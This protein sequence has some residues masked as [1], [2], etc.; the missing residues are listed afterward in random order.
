MSTQLSSGLWRPLKRHR[1]YAKF[2]D[3]KWICALS[4]SYPIYA[5]LTIKFSISHCQLPP[6][7]EFLAHL[8][9]TYVERNTWCLAVSSLHTRLPLS[10]VL[11]WLEMKFAYYLKATRNGQ[12]AHS[13]D[14]TGHWA[15]SAE[16]LQLDWAPRT[17]TERRGRVWISESWDW[18]CGTVWPQV[19][20]WNEQTSKT[21]DDDDDDDR[22]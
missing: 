17:A 11:S 8:F 7:A 13:L 10:S 15:A 9:S 1:F 16:P 4:F 5:I 19:R 2:V 6:L 3:K 20:L 18:M 14:S 21:I 12:R 22:C